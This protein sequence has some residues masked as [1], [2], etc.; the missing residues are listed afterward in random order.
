MKS[1]I[2]FLL[3]FISITAY[4]KSKD[5]IGYYVTMDNVKH[6]F[7]KLKENPNLKKGSFHTFSNKLTFKYGNEKAQYK[8]DE[9]KEKL[10]KRIDKK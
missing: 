2:T 3:I 1:L 10:L 8:I 9:I 4:S 5:S 7:K 6:P